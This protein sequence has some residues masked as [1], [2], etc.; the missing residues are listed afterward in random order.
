MEGLRF[1]S[2]AEQVLLTTLLVKLAVMAAAATILVRFR[3]YRQFLIFE[4]CPWP[5]RVTFANYMRIGPG[6]SRAEV[7][8]MLGPAPNLTERQF[9]RRIGMYGGQKWNF[10]G[11]K[12][13]TNGQYDA[14]LETVLPQKDDYLALRALMKENDWITPKK[15]DMAD[16]A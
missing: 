7:L 3:T 11:T 5:D 4:H 6:T 8:A 16:T 9:N 13:F 14:Y 2:S 10:E 1:L 15:Q 12:Q